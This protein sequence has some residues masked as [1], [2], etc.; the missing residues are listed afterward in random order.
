MDKRDRVRIDQIN[1]VGQFGITNAADWTP[2]GGGPATPAQTNAAS[3]YDQLNTPDTGI[4]A[5]LGTFGTGRAT[6]A[7]DSHGGV[8]SK[9]TVRNGIM[10]DLADWNEAAGAIASAQNKPEIMAGFH[11]PHG[12][13]MEDF[14]NE[15]NA[16]IAAATPL[17]SDFV[18][19]GF[20]AT[21]IQ[22]MK[23]RVTAFGNAKDDKDEGLQKQ[24]G[25]HGGSSATIRAGLTVTKQLNV[26]MKNLYNGNAEKTAAWATASH[27]ER[28]GTSG[29]K[30]PPG[31][32]GT[33]PPAK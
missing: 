23:D 28:V 19:L 25:S 16:I 30:K 2:A 8:V 26:L 18:A 22:D 21:F 5:Q 3:L 27:I 17:E 1:R 9:A 14:P 4:V 11:P 29:K 12:V 7:A 20:A 33:T 10:L 15:V 32:S 24:V 6:G 31:N 13:S